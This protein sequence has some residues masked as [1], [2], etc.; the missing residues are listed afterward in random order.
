VCCNAKSTHF[1]E[2][3]RFNQPASAGIES[4][5]PLTHGESDQID[6]RIAEIRA[7]KPFVAC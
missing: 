3:E 1:A 6:A 7:L 5:F 4:D 2:C